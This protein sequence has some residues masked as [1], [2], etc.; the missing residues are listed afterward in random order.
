M[1]FSIASIYFFNTA[2]EHRNNAHYVEPDLNFDLCYLVLILKCTFSTN[3]VLCYEIKKRLRINSNNPLPSNI[4]KYHLESLRR[5][6]FLFCFE[7][8][9][10]YT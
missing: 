2:E 8:D 7:T 6:F 4:Y 10:D 3:W 1:C 5:T 9:V